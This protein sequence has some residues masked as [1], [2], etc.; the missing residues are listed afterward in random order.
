MTDVRL[1]PWGDGDLAAL[2]RANAPE[3]MTHL[4][5]S[6]TEEKLL[7]RDARYVDGWRTGAAT[8]FRVV[9]DE[10]PEGVGTIGYW[11]HDW[12]GEP[13]L[14]AGWTIES[15]YQGRGY[16]TQALILVIDHAREHS[17]R[18][19]LHAFPKTDNAASNAICRKA[20]MTLLGEEDFEYPKGNPIRSNDWAIEL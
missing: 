7:E 20:G 12:L 5:G 17:D 10:H 6:E 9:T 2:R 8:M 18:R 1:E 3:L 15:D 4:G 19:W 11:H 16:A 14:E 13:R